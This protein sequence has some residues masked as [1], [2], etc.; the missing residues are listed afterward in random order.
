MA[1]ALGLGKLEWAEN[2]VEDF[3][4]HLPADSRQNTYTFNL[5]RVYRFQK[6]YD[7]AITWYENAYQ[8]GGQRT[9]I[10]CHIMAY[11]YDSKGDYERAISLYQEALSYDSSVV[12]IYQRLGELI[13]G[14]DG[15]IYRTKAAQMRQ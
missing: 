1:S 2:F 6:K 5:A 10:L 3:K 9:R 4:N 14:D 7:E 15:N 13:P 11:I 8:N 12:D